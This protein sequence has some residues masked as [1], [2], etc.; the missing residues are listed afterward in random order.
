LEPEAS[1]AWQQLVRLAATIGPDFVRGAQADTDRFEQCSVEAESVLIDYSRCP[2]T[3]EILTALEALADE[4]QLDAAI[5]EMVSGAQINNTESRAALHMA[6][7]GTPVDD[8]AAATQARTELEA[9]LKF[10]DAVRDGAVTG[11]TGQRF[12]TVINIGIGGSD[13]GPRLV[14]CALATPADPVELRFVAGVDGI[15]LV[16]ALADADPASTLFI[17]CSK[18]FTTLETRTNADA[19][20][21]WLAQ[22]DSGI[23]PRDHFCAVSTNAE[24]MDDFGVHPD[25]RFR[26]WDWVGG[27]YSVWSAI[28]LAAAIAIGSDKFRSF[29]AGAR[30]MDDHF[31]NAP[32][33]DN[34]PRVLAMLGIWEQNFLG[35]NALVI[36]P[37]DQRLEFLPAYLQQLYME[38]QGK[39]VGRDGSQMPVPTGIAVWGTPGSHAQH[40]FAQWLHQGFAR[41]TTEYVG[42]VNGSGA[43]ANHGQQ[44]ALANMLAQADVLAHGRTAAEIDTENAE[45]VPHKAHPGSRSA[46]IMLLKE[47]SPEALGALLAQ[48][49]HRVFVQSV[50]WGINPFDQWGVELGKIQAR[51]YAE[52]LESGDVAG[53]PGVGRRIL[54]WTDPED[55]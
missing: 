1:A 2:V 31:I 34:V 12:R 50:I 47:L 4:R 19:A 32:F 10:A 20:M 41:V 54:Q 43:A 17:I 53:L 15:E 49:E 25:W 18:T 36:L 11:S 30:R 35:K 38:S 42:V 21:T 9:F 7:R 48:Y 3:P 33:S 55:E 39:A 8:A 26:I 28:G 22:A 46:V 27:R 29:L 13:L 5:S 23:D 37:Y 16:D 6:L 44:L 14:A 40:S 52:K 45:L 24:A 51:G